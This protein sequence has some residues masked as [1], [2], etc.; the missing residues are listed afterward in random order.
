MIVDG[1][2]RHMNLKIE[3]G[4]AIEVKVDLEEGTVEWVFSS[5]LNRMLSKMFSRPQPCKE[6]IPLELRMGELYAA[7]WIL[8]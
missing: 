1:T 6:S 2:W 4:D 8:S 5:P 3:G 7:C